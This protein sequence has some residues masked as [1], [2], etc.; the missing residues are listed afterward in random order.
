MKNNKICFALSACLILLIGLSGSVSAVYD[1][2]GDYGSS[3]ENCIPQCNGKE[4]GNSDGCGGTCACSGGKSCVYYEKYDWKGYC[5]PDCPSEKVYDPINEKCITPVQSCQTGQC[6]GSCGSCNSGYN[7]QINQA[8]ASSYTTCCK[9]ACL[10]STTPCDS[11]WSIFDGCNLPPDGKAFDLSTGQLVNCKG[12]GTY[13][14]SGKTCSNGQCIAGKT[15]TP[16]RR[17]YSSTSTITRTSANT[18]NDAS[19]TF[20]PSYETISSSYTS[21]LSIASARAAS[22]RTNS[23][24]NI[25]SNTKTTSNVRSTQITA[26]KRG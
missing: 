4:C 20:I 10:D 16:W 25:N 8:T 1:S 15:A 23:V 21:A 22:S 7:C 19:V 24:T 6:G 2:Y 12:I 18:I 26:R 14:P 3:N 13:C 9:S 11:G 5:T 17:R